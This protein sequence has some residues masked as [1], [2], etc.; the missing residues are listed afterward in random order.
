MFRSLSLLLLFA[1]LTSHPFTTQGQVSWNKKIL[2]DGIEWEVKSGSGGPGPNKWS[3]S[4]KSVWVDQDGLHLKIRRINGVWHCAEVRTKAKTLYGMH[5]F[6]VIGRIDSMDQNV[7]F[8]PFLYADD[9]K[10]LDIE[11]TKWA[12]PYWPYNAQYVV[13]PGPYISGDNYHPF[14]FSLSGTYTTHYINWTDSIVNFKSIHG[15]YPEPPSPGFLIQEF[16]YSGPKNPHE[17]DALRVHINLWLVNGWA[18]TDKKPVEVVISA[19]DLPIGP[20][21]RQVS[22]DRPSEIT[23]SSFRANWHVLN[24]VSGYLLDVATD[25]TFSAFVPGYQ[26]LDVGKSSG[27]TIAGLN[28]GLTYYYRVLPYYC[29]DSISKAVSRAVRYSEVQKLTLP[30]IMAAE[31]IRSYPNPVS[32][33]TT[34]EF[35]LDNGGWVELAVC[36]ALG[37]VVDVIM[38]DHLDAGH[39]R[40]SWAPHHLPDGMYFYRLRCGNHYLPVQ[41][42]IIQR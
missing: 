10:E 7:V 16:D 27:W 13:Q 5:R 32:E 28:S 8:A 2:F 40:I 3:N 18:P 4:P 33:S 29:Q 9:A 19:V 35:S 11:F 26:S 21:F 12:D 31:R 1:L 38:N 36:N 34:V 41:Q 42:L 39:Y 6:Y 25:S 30:S 17:S 14:S 22:M 20:Q 37:S 23:S 24:G 15:H